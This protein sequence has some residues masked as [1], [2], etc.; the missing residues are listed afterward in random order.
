MANAKAA[1]PKKTL[2]GVSENK[3]LKKEQLRRTEGQPEYIFYDGPPFATGLPHYGHILAGTLKDI[4]TRY[5]AST[6]HHVTRRFGWDCHGLPVEYEI[7]K[8]LVTCYQIVVLNADYCFRYSKEW[9]VTV[10]RLGRWIDFENDYKTLDPQFMESVWWVFKQLFDKGL[11]YRGF[12]VM[13]FSTACST[14]LSNFEAGLNYKDVDDP[15]VMVRDPAKGTVYLVAEAR[16]AAL[17]GAVPKAPAFGEDDY[18]WGEGLPC[19]VDLNGRFTTEVTDFAG[20]Y[21]KEADKEIIAAIKAAGRLVDHASLNHSYP[22]CWRSDTPLIYRAV[23]SWFVKVESFKDRLLL[24]NEQTY[25]V[26]AYVKEKRFHNWLEGAHDWAISRSRF[27]GTPIPIWASE[28]GEEVRVI[29]SIEELEKV[30]GRK[31]TDLHRHFIDDITIPSSQGKGLLRRVDDVFD[32]WFESGSM[33]YGQNKE[34]FENNF[35]ADFVAEGLD[36]TRGWL[37]LINSP[38]VRAETLRF[39]EEGVFGVVKDVFLPWYNAYRF[40]VQNVLRWELETGEV[41]MPSL[42][43]QQ[44]GSSSSGESV[45]DRWI[46]AAV[47]SLTAFVRSEMEGYRL[48]TVVPRLVS[49]IDQLTNIYVRYNRKRLKGG[50]GR[51]DCLAALTTLFNVLLTVAKAVIDAGRTIREKNNRPLKQPLRRVIV[52]HPDPDFLADVTGDLSEYVTGELNVLELETCSDMLAYAELS[53]V[54]DWQ[55]LGK[56]LGKDMGKVAAAVKGLSVSDILA[57]EQSGNILLAGHELSAGDIKVV[58]SFKPPAGVAPG[59]LDASG[60]GEVLVVLD[61]TVQADL[62]EQG[63]AREVVNRYQKLRKKAGLTVTDAAYLK[64]ALGVEL[65]PLSSKP[66]HHLVITQ[67]VQSVGGGSADDGP[68]ASFLAVIAAPPGSTAA[69]A[70]GGVQQMSLA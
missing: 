12:K 29:G 57:F 10:K 23:P 49:F 14:S 17:P 67:E 51:E 35:P 60:D 61:L 63:L 66:P 19:P 55:A 65:Q 46:A 56:R 5:A 31:I 6:G 64:E 3:Y 25:W 2:G 24:N 9:E 68:S 54:P 21:V 36:Q 38:V 43:Q 48:Y 52:V 70:A 53:A 37:Y 45:L 58:R 33:P 32:C 15:A 47:R 34:L 42:H 22:F 7:D 11:V 44:P 4:V 13:P 28:D 69:A 41:F 40:L 62:L 18:R 8:K 20:K 50:K 39:K 26:P 1:S 59:E 27:W 16:L 30:A